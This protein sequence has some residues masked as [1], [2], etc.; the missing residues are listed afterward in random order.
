MR[1]VNSTVNSP[2][3]H[4]SGEQSPARLARDQ[5]QDNRADREAGSAVNTDKNKSPRKDKSSA[6]WILLGLLGA[7]IATW[8][9]R[10]F[11]G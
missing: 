8:L 1:T 2:V 3:E 10:R 9:I 7:G 6:G 5:E 11:T 4:V